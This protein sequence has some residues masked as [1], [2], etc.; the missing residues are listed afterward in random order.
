MSRDNTS[1]TPDLA[2]CYKAVQDVSRTFALTIESLKPPLSD[3]ICVG[4]L[5]CRIPDTIED[6]SHI[7]VTDQHS[8]LQEYHCAI[9]P[10]SPTQINSFIAKVKPWI[11]KG[12]ATSDWELVSNT[13]TI[14]STFESF[15]RATKEAMLPPI[16]ELTVGMYKFIER[17]G[18]NPGIRIQT[19]AELKSYCHYVAGTVGTL[20]TN[21]LSTQSLS[22]DRRV[23]LRTT[24]EYFGRLLQLVNIAKDVHNDYQEENNIYLPAVWLADTA[25][26]QSEILA[27]THRSD[28]VT[29]VE[30]VIDRAEDHANSAQ[31]YIRSMPLNN[32]NTFTAWAIPY[33]L[34]IGTLR[35]LRERPAAA[36]RSDSVKVSRQEVKAIGTTVQSLDRHH[37][38]TLRERVADRPLLE[39]TK[40]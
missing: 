35:E 18:D 33:L 23:T 25:V 15:N 9:N 1:T 34:A 21:L 38:E 28:V 14:L 24:G 8:L 26:P 40:L 17:Y 20:I 11:L 4:Y 12:T 31:A 36:L 22:E 13:P 30:R 32:G 37:I 3:Q 10:D 6:A 27:E 7:P 39:P 5:L 2:Y 16:Q 19:G 29:V